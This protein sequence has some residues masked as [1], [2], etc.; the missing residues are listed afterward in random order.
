MSFLKDMHEQQE[1][2][3]AHKVMLRFGEGTY[4]REP[5]VIRTSASL[6]I[7]TG[8]DHLTTLQRLFL[9]LAESEQISAKG[10]IVAPRKTEVLDILDQYDIEPKKVWGIKITLDFTLERERCKQMRDQLAQTGA[11]VLLSMSAGKEQ[12]KTKTAL[13][14]PGKLVESFVKLTLAKDH[15][16]RVCTEFV[17]G[18]FKKSVRIEN[19]YE[20]KQVIYDEELLRKDPKRG[21]LESKRDVTIHRTITT[22]GEETTDTISAIV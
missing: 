15:K 17:V 12:L 6:T 9:E 16:E 18:D 14:K 4:Q 5:I 19:R 22:D 2:E 1:S 20:I 11:Y 10:V 8:Y 3:E 13:P 21:R 7:T